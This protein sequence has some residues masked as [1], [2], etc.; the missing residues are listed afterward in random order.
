MLP[1][2]DERVSICV[3]RL[4]GLKIVTFKNFDKKETS[5]LLYAAI[6]RYNSSSNLGEEGLIENA[7]LASADIAK[8]WQL[9]AST[10][11]RSPAD[12]LLIADGCDRKITYIAKGRNVRR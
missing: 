12:S 10:L 9:R 5:F 4:V 1:I 2:L 8:E 11:S 3:S 6:F 7:P